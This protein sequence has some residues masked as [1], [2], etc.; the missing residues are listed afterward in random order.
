MFTPQIKA[1]KANTSNLTLPHQ[2]PYPEAVVHELQQKIN[3]TKR[4]ETDD[5]EWSG[6]NWRTDGDIMVNGAFFV[7]S[8]A[9]M[10]AQYA[11]AS[12]VQPKS[13]VQIDQLTMYSGVFGDPRIP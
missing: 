3:V 5:K 8:G 9:G 10:S 4:V 13:V 6:W 2:H 11:E 7:P 1:S 12:S